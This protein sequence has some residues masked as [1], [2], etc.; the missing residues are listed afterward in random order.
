MH[1]FQIIDMSEQITKLEDNLKE[2]SNDILLLKNELKMVNE[3]RKKRNKLTQEFTEV[4]RTTYFSH[5]NQ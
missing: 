5:N 1:L 2:K 3:F 4:N